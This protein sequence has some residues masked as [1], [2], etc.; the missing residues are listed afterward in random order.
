MSLLK[1]PVSGRAWFHLMNQF[2]IQ[3]AYRLSPHRGSHPR[4]EI[5]RA[6]EN[7]TQCDNH[8]PAGELWKV[9]EFCLGPSTH[10]AGTECSEGKLRMW[11]EWPCLH[12]PSR[13]SWEDLGRELRFEKTASKRSSVAF[14]SFSI[15]EDEDTSLPRTASSSQCTWDENHLFFFFF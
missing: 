1:R 3:K 10:V 9:A 14:V 15:S 8:P 5:A 7:R 2:N 13:G 4:Q 12:S 11:S 6:H